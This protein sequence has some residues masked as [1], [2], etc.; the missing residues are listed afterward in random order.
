MNDFKRGYNILTI[1]TVIGLIFIVLIASIGP[2]IDSGDSFVQGEVFPVLVLLPS[3]L[4]LDLN[5]LYSKYT[6]DKD[7]SKDL[8]VSRKCGL[9]RM[10]N[11]NHP[12]GNLI[13]LGGMIIVTSLLIWKVF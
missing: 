10:I 7:S 13:W 2:F 8:I 12:I 9:G 5:Y 3:L 11:P 6:K 1:I 4:L